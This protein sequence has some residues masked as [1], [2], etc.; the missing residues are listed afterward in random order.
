MKR[1]AAM[2]LLVLLASAFVYVIASGLARSADMVECDLTYVLEVGSKE[3]CV[4]H[5]SV[6]A[7][8]SATLLKE[9]GELAGAR[10]QVE[11]EHALRLAHEERDAA[12]LAAC[13]QSRSACEA[14]RVPPKCEEPG[15]LS[16]PEVA[17]PVGFVLGF[18]AGFFTD[19][20]IK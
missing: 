2:V 9:E 1:W 13:N 4:D 7:D 12:F 8:Y 19:R 17:W 15:T 11:N 5:I 10:A 16:K 18:F 14:S 3:R 20:A 6:P